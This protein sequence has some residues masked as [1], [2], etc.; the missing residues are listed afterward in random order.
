MQGSLHA[1]ADK[2]V[3]LHAGSRRGLSPAPAAAAALLA[4]AALRRT[5]GLLACGPRLA[6]CRGALA[7][8]LAAGL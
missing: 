8:A 3:H 5:P 7:A 2:G 1:Y 6:G 4:R